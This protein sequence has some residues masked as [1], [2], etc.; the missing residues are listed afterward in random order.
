M[1]HALDHFIKGS[2]T[3]GGKNHL[4]SLAN[5]F[6]GELS[7]G[8]GAGRRRHGNR[9]AAVPQRPYRA[10]QPPVS[11]AAKPA[12]GRIVDQCRERRID[13][14]VRCARVLGL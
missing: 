9:T 6:A 5:R 7:S 11:R 2:V 8:A 3:A 10:L 13:R 4:A 1:R 14:L 12:R